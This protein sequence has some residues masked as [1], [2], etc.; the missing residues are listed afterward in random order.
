MIK[1]KYFYL[2]IISEHICTEMYRHKNRTKRLIYTTATWNANSTNS[3]CT[4]E[5]KKQANNNRKTVCREVMQ[6]EA[7]AFVNLQS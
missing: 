4:K 5:A 3:K 6:K 2:Y 1:Q 7:E